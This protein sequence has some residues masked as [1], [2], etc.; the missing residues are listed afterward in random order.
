MFKISTELLN[1]NI[2]NMVMVSQASNFVTIH[3]KGPSA[4]QRMGN[5]KVPQTNLIAYTTTSLVKKRNSIITQYK[6]DQG[7]TMNSMRQE[8][9]NSH[10]SS[11]TS[12]SKGKGTRNAL[13]GKQGLKQEFHHF[14]NI[15]KSNNIQGQGLRKSLYRYKNFT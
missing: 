5:S 1:P 14:A 3:T 7:L 8:I 15:I 12:K 11:T 2:D 13:Y 10:Y 9:R 6:G 4:T